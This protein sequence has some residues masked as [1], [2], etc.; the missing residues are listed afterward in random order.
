[1]KEP[2]QVLAFIYL[3]AKIHDVKISSFPP[4]GRPEMA[5]RFFCGTLASR[6]R[7]SRKQNRSPGCSDLL[8]KITKETKNRPGVWGLK[9][10]SFPKWPL[11]LR[12]LR[13]L[14]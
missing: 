12:Y 13:L 6:K 7:E 5:V 4:G 1:M 14:L 11:L 2:R 9:F 8:Q 3:I 10:D